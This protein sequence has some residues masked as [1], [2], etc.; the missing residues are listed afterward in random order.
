[1]FDTHAVEQLRQRWGWVPPV[2]GLRREDVIT[3]AA[4]GRHP[5]GLASVRALARASGLSPTAAGRAMRRLVEAGYVERGA[6]RVVEGRVRERP[7]WTVRFGS[8]EWLAVA[9]RV[10]TTVLSRQPAG[11]RARRVPGRLG[12][13]FWN[14]D[15]AR[16]SLDRNA[17]L[18]AGRILRSEDPEALAWMQEAVPA[19]AIDAA[20]RG[21]G[22]DARRARLGRL[23][24]HRR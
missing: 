6:I 9:A 23:L 21:R 3:L 17:T 5:L 2:P 13:L 16:L 7:I 15:L 22:I 1:M 14:E 11:D 18:I 4:L 19:A 8:P 24:A 10:S 20:S 12:H